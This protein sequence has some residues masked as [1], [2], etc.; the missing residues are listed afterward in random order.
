MQRLLVVSNHTYMCGRAHGRDLD[1]VVN[2]VAR[3]KWAGAWP[4]M[5]RLHKSVQFVAST[6]GAAER[7]ELRGAPLLLDPDTQAC[8]LAGVDTV[9]WS[10]GAD[11]W[12]SDK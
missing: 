5:C 2:V 9:C 1:T 6:W 8:F 12:T 10:K 11:V 4:A 7:C 3:E